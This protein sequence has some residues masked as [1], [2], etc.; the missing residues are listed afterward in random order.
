[1]LFSSDKKFIL[2]LPP[3]TAST[4]ISNAFLRSGIKFNTSHKILDYPIFHLKL[5]EMCEWHELD[6]IDEYK[7]LQFTRNPY[8]RFVSSYYQLLRITSGNTNLKF[9]GMNFKEFVYHLDE[10]K[11]SENFTKSFFGDDSHYHENIR[12]KKNWSGIRMFDEQVSYNDL[13]NKINYFKIENTLNDMSLVSE[14]IGSQIN[15]VNNLNKNPVE[16]DYDS[17]LD[18]E[19]MGIIHRNFINDFEILGY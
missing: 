12:L 8:H 19:C 15:I 1:M 6:N 4:S 3:K 18:E 14:L 7:V 17:L 2:L 9:Y 16:I 10:S 11:S 13:N 5:S